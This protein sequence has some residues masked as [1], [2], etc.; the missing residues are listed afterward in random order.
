[1]LLNQ[2]HERRNTNT[3]SIKK[4]II[5]V[6]VATIVVV[7]NVVYNTISFVFIA[8]ITFVFNF[9]NATTSI[10]L[11]TILISSTI[12]IMSTILT[13]STIS[14]ISIYSSISFVFKFFNVIIE[15][16]FSN[17]IIFNNVIIHRL[18]NTK[19][20]VVIINKFLIL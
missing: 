8:S 3:N 12:L 20:F 13:I 15:K 6:F 7:V 2:L 18:I 16:F 19:T 11:L 5:F 10:A 17:L 14:T 4:N 9:L 1:M